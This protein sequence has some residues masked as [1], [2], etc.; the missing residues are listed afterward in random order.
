MLP[1]WQGY[2]AANET[3]ES[4]LLCNRPVMAALQSGGVSGW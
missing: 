1:K 2:R 4:Y 3:D